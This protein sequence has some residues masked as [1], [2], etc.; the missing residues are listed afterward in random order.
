MLAE[1]D[2]PRKR[3]VEYVSKAENLRCERPHATQYAREGDGRRARGR[4]GT[5]RGS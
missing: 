2:F 3:R 5:E 4:S 1:C